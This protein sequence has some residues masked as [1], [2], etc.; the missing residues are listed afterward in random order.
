MNAREQSPEE[1]D[2]I[3]RA[4]L[5]IF[6][7]GRRSRL[8]PRDVGLPLTA[9]RRVVGLRREEIAELC[10]VSIDW[11]RWFE[12]GRSIRVSVQ[13]L[14]KLSQALRLS[15]LEQISLYHLAVP[16]VYLAYVS[17]CHVSIPFLTD[18]AS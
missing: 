4:K 9:R 10:G 1:I 17:Q 2:A 3:R 15:P 6:L 13:F 18:E 7:A 5:K 8:T 12:S 14:A 16:E 11:Y